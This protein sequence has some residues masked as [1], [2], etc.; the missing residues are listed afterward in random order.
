V[1]IEGEELGLIP[2]DRLTLPLEPCALIARRMAM[3]LPIGSG[4][5]QG[6]SENLIDDRMKPSGIRR[7]PDGAEAILNL[8]AVYLSELRSTASRSSSAT[9]ILIASSLSR[10]LA[11]WLASAS[12]AAQ[13]V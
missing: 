1:V 9:A 12:A 7:S 6:T 3:A 5:I 13:V 11:S 4:V 10:A 8:G 2:Y